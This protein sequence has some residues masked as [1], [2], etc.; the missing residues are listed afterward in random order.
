MKHYIKYIVI[1]G[2][3]LILLL[4]INPRNSR[5]NLFKD[6][7][8]SISQQRKDK[9]NYMQ[10]DPDSPFR[11]MGIR[12][13]SLKY[14]SIDPDFK[15]TAR[16]NPFPIQERIKMQMN[17]GS[18]E[19]FIK[20]ATVDFT[21]KGASQHLILFK[22]DNNASLSAYFLPF[23]DETSSAETYGGGRFLDPENDGG[24]SIVLDFNLAYNPYCAYAEGYVC[25]LPP[26][27]NKITIAVTAGEKIY[28]S[29]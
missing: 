3:A 1:A 15:V 21:I 29:H 8:D 12:F 25:P 23:F 4:L 10:N 22:S 2:L 5:P 19:Y 17:D 28:K 6:Y 7:R 27:E 16:L 13:D 26:L 11:T 14:F 18:L 9:E 20:Y 24:S